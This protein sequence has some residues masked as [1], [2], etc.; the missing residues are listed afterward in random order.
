MSPARP[1]PAA[2]SNLAIPPDPSSPLRRR[3]GPAMRIVRHFWNGALSLMLGT[4]IGIVG[5]QYVGD[6]AARLWPDQAI[7][8][9][10]VRALFW[11]I[12]IATTGLLFFS[13]Y[14]DDTAR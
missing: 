12:G 14:L 10:L 2:K 1:P 4:M 9:E 5:H 13:Y 6:A 11:T 8:A 7:V 3:E